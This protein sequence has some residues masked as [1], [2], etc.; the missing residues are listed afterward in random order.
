MVAAEVT[1]AQANLQSATA[2]VDQADRSLRTGI[3]R[4]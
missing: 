1:E 3:D 4:L 2:R